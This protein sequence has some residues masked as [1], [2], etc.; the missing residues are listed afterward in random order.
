MA[1]SEASAFALRKVT[2]ASLTGA[3]GVFTNYCA[4]SFKMNRVDSVKA[5]HYTLRRSFRFITS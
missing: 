1:A 3:E 5:G 4:Q 2:Q